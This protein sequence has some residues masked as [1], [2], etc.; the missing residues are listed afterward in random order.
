MD[1]QS[2]FHFMLNLPVNLAIF[3]QNK[4]RFYW[5]E[6]FDYRGWL[7]FPTPTHTILFGPLLDI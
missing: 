3:K 7:G 6:M 5:K 4:D 1:I 2:H